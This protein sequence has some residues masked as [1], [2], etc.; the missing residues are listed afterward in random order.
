MHNRQRDLISPDL[1]NIPIDLIGA[2]GIGSWTALGLAKMGCSDVTITD[3]DVIEVE[4]LGSQVYGLSDVGRNKAEA[5]VEQLASLTGHYFTAIPEAFNPETAS[6]GKGI[7]ISAVDNMDV[8]RQLFETLKGL[9][10]W[11]I[12]G[13]MAANEINLYAV[14][15]AD[16]ES[17][18][19]YEKTLFSNAEARDIPCSMRAVMYNTMMVGSLITDHVAHIARQEELP[20]EIIVDLYNYDMM[21]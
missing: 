14:N 8:R 7:V 13:R 11:F 20:F 6:L 18:S 19:K 17:V 1:L 2:G 10:N 12:D 4:N 21:K 5:L 15:M 16:P 3:F 9:G